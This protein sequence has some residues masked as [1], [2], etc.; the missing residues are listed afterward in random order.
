MN[1]FLRIFVPAISLSFLTGCHID[2]LRSRVGNPLKQVEF[3][4]L[5]PKKT[6]RAEAV[7]KLGAPEKVEWKNGKDYHWYLYKDKLDTGIRFQFPPFR[8]IFGYQHTFLRLNEAAED[9]NAMELVYD[10]QGVLERKSMRLS[11]AYQPT[12]DDKATWKFHLSTHGDHSVAL[13]GSGGVR[14]YDEM[15]SNGYRVGLGLGWQPVPVVTLLGRTGYQ[16]Y[17]G[18]ERRIGADLV[19][20]G[21]LHLYGVEIG[22][23]L[24]A[25]LNLLWS[26]QDFDN[27]K[28]VL[29]EEDLSRSTGLKIYVEGTTGVVANSNVP[30]KI[31]GV[32]RGHF[33]DNYYQFSGSLEAGAEYGWSWGAVHAGVS[34]QTMDPFNEGNSPLDADAGSFQALFV[35]G[36]LSV[37]F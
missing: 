33:Y 2:I 20:F 27:V 17:Q 10:E 3:A 19:S 4:Q 37:K 18:K 30:V 25:P 16:E 6:T 36:G 34:Y 31:N 24:A 26:F 9:T 28:R 13:L 1:A 8:S 22:V 11:K 23:R 5:E 12:P 21:D 7:E 14:D 29:F 15:F 35:G 32:R